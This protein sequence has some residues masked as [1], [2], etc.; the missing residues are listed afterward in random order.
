MALK[1][2]NKFRLVIA[3]CVVSS[4][5]WFIAAVLM[6]DARDAGLGGDLAVAIALFTLFINANFLE[7]LKGPKANIEEGLKELNIT[8]VKGEAVDA[9]VER[10]RAAVEKLF[11]TLVEESDDK[12]R[13]NK[14]LAWATAVGVIV[15]AF[16]ERVAE[17]ILRSP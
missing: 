13:E 8:R 11:R 10:I 4:V 17:W 15:G 2:R 3:A 7:A 1:P 14:S 16:G 6:K 12:S 9:S 5:G